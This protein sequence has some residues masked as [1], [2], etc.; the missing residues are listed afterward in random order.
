MKER[1]EGEGVGCGGG[2]SVLGWVGVVRLVAQ[3]VGWLVAQLV[4]SEGQAGGG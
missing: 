3:L 4:V 1:V 2:G